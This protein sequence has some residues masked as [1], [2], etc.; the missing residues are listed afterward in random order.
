MAD[1][2][3]LKQKYQPVLEVLAKEDATINAVD[4]QGD[5][6]HLQATVVSEASK[7]RVWDA[8]KAVDP[9]FADS[10]AH[11]PTW[12]PV[13]AVRN[14]R[15][16][17]APHLPFGWVDLPPSANRLIGLWWL[18]KKLYPDLFPEDL[19]ALTRDFYRRYYHV[20]INDAQIDRVLAGR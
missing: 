16:E 14:G 7:N 10:A 4:L 19:R 9:T 2:A 18:G 13:A 3:T 12:A 11:D 20:A 5:Q 17:L 6:L 1:L 15:I 8:I